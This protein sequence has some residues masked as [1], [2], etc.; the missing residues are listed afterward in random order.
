MG[1]A[2]H[3]LRSA[4][5]IIAAVLVAAASSAEEPSE[6][7][8]TSWRGKVALG[9]SVTAGN[10]DAVKLNFGALG[11]KQWGDHLVKLEL[12]ASYG[13]SNGS[14]DSDK[15][16][17]SEYYRHSLRDRLYV[18]VDALQGRDS[19]QDID[20]RFLLNSGPGWHLWE[21]S[22][23]EFFDIEIGLGYRY[24]NYSTAG[25]RND[26]VGRTAV[27]YSNLFGPA[28]FTQSAEFLLP[29]NDTGGWLA[30]AR[31]TLAFPLTDSW[32][33]TNSLLIEYLNAPV[34]GNKGFDLE[35]VVGLSYAF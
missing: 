10:S 2:Q 7:Q 8:D 6:E 19:V 28:E 34:A 14:T 11:E 18:Y 24:E 13:R 29:F 25:S 27:L 32:S 26:V 23:Q 4:L 5:P 15:Q 30:T 31:T 35:Y 21:T 20:F 12:L 22:A 17:L 3:I 9:G 33:F 16:S 1:S